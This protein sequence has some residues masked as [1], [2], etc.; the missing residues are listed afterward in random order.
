MCSGFLPT[1]IVTQAQDAEINMNFFSEHGTWEILDNEINTFLNPG[2]SYI[3]MDIKMKRRPAFAVINIV[4]PM[5]FM[6]VL[7]LLVFV[8]PVESGE[9]LSFSITVLLAIAVF[10]T[11]VG[12]NLPKTSKPTAILSYFLLTDLVLSSLICFFVILGLCFYHKDETKTPV[13]TSIEK[14]VTICCHRRKCTNRIKNHD[15]TVVEHFNGNSADNKFSLPDDEEDSD[16]LKVTWKMVSGC[17]DWIILITSLLVIF[18]STTL[19]FVM[20]M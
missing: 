10:M 11:L 5:I 18:I 19:Y 13:P 2:V 14:I 16:E 9:R 8:L 6:V 7:N 1:D 3:S 4:L 17:F 15:Q 12:D 20:T